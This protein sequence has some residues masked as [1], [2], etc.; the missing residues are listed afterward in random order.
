MPRIDPDSIVVVTPVGKFLKVEDHGT[1]FDWLFEC[2]G[3]GAWA[4]LDDDQFHGRVSV[5]HVD[6]PGGYHE[7]HDFATAISEAS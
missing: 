1:S 2:P 4:N 6:C 7:T 5:W 3:C